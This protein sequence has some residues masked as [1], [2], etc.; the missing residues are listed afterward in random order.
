MEEPGRPPSDQSDHSSAA[1]SS[2]SSASSAVPPD[3]VAVSQAE[4]KA[5]RFS[6][7]YLGNIPVEEGQLVPGEC[8]RVVH[9]A[10]KSANTAGN[11][12]VHIH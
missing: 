5:H 12:K 6:V 2:S 10:I 4:V 3:M 8:V 7:L 11:T 9:S 1:S